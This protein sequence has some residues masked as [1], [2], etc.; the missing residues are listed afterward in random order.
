MPAIQTKPINGDEDFLSAQEGINCLMATHGFRLVQ[1]K[2]SATWLAGAGHPGHEGETYFKLLYQG[3]GRPYV[4]GIRREFAQTV[5]KLQ[6]LRWPL[7]FVV[8]PATEVGFLGFQ[9]PAGNEEL[10]RQRVE[11]ILG[12]LPEPD[13]ALAILL[14]DGADDAFDEQLKNL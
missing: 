13:P 10:G 6:A 12:T 14:D 3:K 8:M 4:F 5:E 7:E 2:G 11:K 9:I 1:H